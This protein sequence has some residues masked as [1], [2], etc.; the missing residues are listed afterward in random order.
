MR[1]EADA[2]RNVAVGDA[3]SKNFWKNMNREWFGAWPTVI[4]PPDVLAAFSG[5]VVTATAAMKSDKEAV[6]IKSNQIKD[7]RLTDTQ[8]ESKVLVLQPQTPECRSRP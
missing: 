4:V 8:S 5:D 6:C 2:S 3:L 1:H 7:L